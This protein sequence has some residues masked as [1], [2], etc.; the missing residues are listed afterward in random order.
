LDWI[1]DVNYN[2]LINYNLTT[3]WDTDYNNCEM[4]V[5]EM[6]RYIDSMS[7]YNSC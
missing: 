4:I 7:N 2:I 1:G 5:S 6:Q 3:I